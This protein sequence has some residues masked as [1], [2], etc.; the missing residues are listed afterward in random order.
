MFKV[1]SKLLFH[2]L[3]Y[4]IIIINKHPFVIVGVA[5]VMKVLSS[6][7]LFKCS[8]TLSMFSYWKS[9]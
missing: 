3:H 5:I 4:L 8:S 1:S 6:W 9:S 7:R 2:S